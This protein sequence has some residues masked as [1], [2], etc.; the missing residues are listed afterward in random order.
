MQYANRFYYIIYG[1]LVT[2]TYSGTKYSKFFCH[3]AKCAFNCLSAPTQSVVN[4]YFCVIQN[5]KQYENKQSSQSSW[6]SFDGG[7]M[8]S[9]K[10]VGLCFIAEALKLPPRQIYHPPPL[11]CHRQHCLKQCLLQK[12]PRVLHHMHLRQQYSE[13]C[14]AI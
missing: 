14:M 7:G 10:L 1:T 2:T 11:Q 6:G 4:N 5:P 13:G 8:S 9:C 12:T 3:H